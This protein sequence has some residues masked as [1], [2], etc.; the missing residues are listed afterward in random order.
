MVDLEDLSQCVGEIASAHAGTVGVSGAVVTA[1][2]LKRWRDVVADAAGEL[3]ARRD[4]TSPDPA[5]PDASDEVRLAAGWE[6]QAQPVYESFNGRPG[7][8]SWMEQPKSTTA[9]GPA[10]L[11]RL[12][13]SGVWVRW[14]VAS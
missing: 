12:H 5:A 7:G 13:A 4:A 3:R 1:P 2:T 14:V 11:W 10:G 6:Q 8:H 9:P